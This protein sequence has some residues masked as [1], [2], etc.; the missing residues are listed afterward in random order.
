MS[1]AAGRSHTGAPR[2][3]G[4]GGGEG[5]GGGGGSGGESALESGTWPA[6]RHHHGSSA[7]ASSRARVTPRTSE[8]HAEGEEGRVLGDQIGARE[9]GARQVHADRP[10][11]HAHAD[12]RPGESVPHE[13][14]PAAHPQQPLV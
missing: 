8:H 4:G 11:R 12:A 2:G 1:D 14:V 13:R 9:E 6:A 5:G 3:A 7:A 10:A